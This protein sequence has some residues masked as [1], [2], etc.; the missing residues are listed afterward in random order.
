L[1][2]LLDEQEMYQKRYD[3]LMA[4]D[5]IAQHEFQRKKNMFLFLG[6]LKASIETFESLVDGG[7]LQKEIEILE[8]EYDKLISLVDRGAIQKRVDKA[9]AVISQ[10]IL[11]HLQTL[12]V[13]DKYRI[14]APK[15]SIKDLNISVLGNEG[16]WHFLA[17]VGSA[18]NW[19]SFHIGL[20]CS[21]QEYFLDL[22]YSCVPSFVIFDQPSQVYFPK[23]KRNEKDTEY[24]A[25]YENEDVQAVKSIF[26]TLANSVLDNQGNWQCIV[27]DHADKSIYGEIDGI[28]EVAEWR[29]GEKL[30]PEEWYT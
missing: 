11:K 4:R 3:L 23:V 2:K 28:Y 15:F 13:E 22:D 20:M 12:D 6:H 17:E 14:I 5:E 27:L 9:T 10:G 30:I 19:V 18:S 25:Q 21:L 24:D 8:K 26:K 1:Q 29:N 16:D 7:D